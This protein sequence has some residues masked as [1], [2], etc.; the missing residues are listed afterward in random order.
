MQRVLEESVGSA[1]LY[2]YTEIHHGH[3]PAD[4]PNR[5]EIMA[6]KEHGH[7]PLC[8]QIRQQIEHLR[9]NGHVERRSGFVAHEQLR[10]GRERARE[11]NALPLSARELV[12]VALSMACIEADRIKQ[13]GY[14]LPSLRCCSDTVN[15]ERLADLVSNWQ[16]PVQRAKRI[17]ED[18]LH[19]SAQQTPPRLV[20]TR[21][22]FTLESDLAGIAPLEAKDQPARGRLAAARLAYEPQRL[23]GSNLE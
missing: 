14:P 22:N 4:L 8:L 13:S 15:V 3:A 20:R 6:D 17:L 5:S 19:A 23:A 1:L 7:A 16:A 2:D 21:K 11:H 9:L 10:V 18:H 12:R